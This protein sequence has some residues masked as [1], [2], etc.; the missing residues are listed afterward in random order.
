[1]IDRVKG[2]KTA[3]L[4]RIDSRE[5]LG[6]VTCPTLVLV[7]EGDLLTPL[8]VSQEIHDCIPGSEL[9]VIEGSGH[10]S[11]LEEPDTVTATLRNFLNG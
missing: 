2:P 6:K 8:P 1:M 9:A 4:G 7:G 3:I 11:T 10:L 5:S